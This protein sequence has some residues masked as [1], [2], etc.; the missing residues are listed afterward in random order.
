MSDNRASRRE[1]RL[2]VAV[3]VIYTVVV[4]AIS[5]ASRGCR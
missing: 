5:L 4:L 3:I 1:A 2:A